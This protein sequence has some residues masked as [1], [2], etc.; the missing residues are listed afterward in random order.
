MVT[1]ETLEKV[2]VQINSILTES[3][4]RINALEEAVEE[5]KKPKR[6]RPA[7]VDNNVSES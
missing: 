7:K 2:I 1:K 4:K 6:G 3:N 5:L